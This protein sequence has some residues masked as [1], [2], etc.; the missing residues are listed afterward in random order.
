MVALLCSLLYLGCTGEGACHLGFRLTNSMAEFE[1]K[2]WSVTRER[3]NHGL[4]NIFPAPTLFFWSD[5]PIACS[6]R[7]E[8]PSSN[9]VLSRTQVNIRAVRSVTYA[10]LLLLLLLPCIICRVYGQVCLFFH[11][12]QRWAGFF[13]FLFLSVSLIMVY[14]V[15]I[16][17]FNSSKYTT[18]NNNVFL[19]VL[20]R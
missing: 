12:R 3:P 11:L 8:V 14:Q 1:T 7:S 15:C 10:L 4:S 9:N 2:K 6:F 16:H 5:N 19:P 20:F 13:C 18:Y 17:V